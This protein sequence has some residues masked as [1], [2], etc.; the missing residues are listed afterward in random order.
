MISDYTK[1]LK[2]SHT[3]KFLNF[4]RT[5]L[6][7]LGLLL[8]PCKSLYAAEE[9][10]LEGESRSAGTIVSAGISSEPDAGDGSDEGA[11]SDGVT[12]RPDASIVPRPFTLKVDSEKVLFE[13]RQK[14]KRRQLMDKPEL[15]GSAES[16]GLSLLIDNPELIER[17]GPHNLNLL[18]GD[19]RLCFGDRAALAVKVLHKD[20]PLGE[21]TNTL[22][23]TIKSLA[24]NDK[25]SITFRRS[26]IGCMLTL[27][28]PYVPRLSITDI[29]NIL[30]MGILH[31]NSSCVARRWIQLL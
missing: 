11:W 3:I 20:M 30:R 15:I 21:D 12:S 22:M 6:L 9:E 19:E 23:K 24:E 18:L 2:I 28:K 29:I 26:L 17:T 8:L 31:H 5:G 27:F 10:F 13:K 14:E 1:C 7:L 25:A 16:F 4:S